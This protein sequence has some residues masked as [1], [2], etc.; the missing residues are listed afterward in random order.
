MCPVCQHGLSEFFDA[1]L[2]IHDEHHQATARE[3]VKKAH[4][5]GVGFVKSVAKEL[6]A[7]FY[8]E[9]RHMHTHPADF[10]TTITVFR[11]DTMADI[12]ACGQSFCEKQKLMW[13]ALI[14]GVHAELA[15]SKQT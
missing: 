5:P 11:M 4:F 13:A 7:A 12:I 6:L 1:F 3:N 8:Q 15:H 2:R 9:L 10:F 14:V